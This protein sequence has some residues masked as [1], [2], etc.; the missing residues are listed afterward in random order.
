MKEDT[1]AKMRSIEESDKNVWD[2]FWRVRTLVM[3]GKTACVLYTKGYGKRLCA[4]IQSMRL[5][6][7]WL[8]TSTYASLGTKM[9]CNGHDRRASGA[10]RRR[11]SKAHTLLAASIMARTDAMRS[12]MGAMI[13]FPRPR[14]PFLLLRAL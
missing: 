6:V 11:N 9:R 4:K 3:R 14:P 10:A 2:V 12:T 13:R 8:P 1:A 7:S 5:F